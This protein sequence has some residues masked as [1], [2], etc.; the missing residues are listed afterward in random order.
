MFMSNSIFVDSSLP[1]EYIKG[2]KRDLM[3]ALLNDKSV[4]LCISQTVVSEYLYYHLAEYGQKSP[5]TLKENGSI[6]RILN[7]MEP[8]PFLA[9]FTWLPDD[10]SMLQLAVDFM[11]K[12]NLL[13]NDALILAACKLHGIPALASFDPDFNAP[14]QGEGIRLLQTAADF[15]AF[16]ESEH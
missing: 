2:A 9:L 16:Q 4:R 13:P 6:P 8:L 14:S 15:E 12:Y 1:V 5:R 10:A 11:G 7:S 3:D